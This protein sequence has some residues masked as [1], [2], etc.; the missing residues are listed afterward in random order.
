MTHPA[1]ARPIAVPAGRRQGVPLPADHAAGIS[2]PVSA[3][4]TQR[5]TIVAGAALVAAV[6]MA[7]SADTLADLGRSVGWGHRLAWSLPVSVDVLALV[8]GLAWLAAGSGRN[9]GRV[10]TL[11]TVGVSVLLNAVG[12]LVS[13][14]H[15]TT[16]P[17]LVIA[18][19]AV[20]PLAA[21]LAVHLGATVN[22]DRTVPSA[23]STP[24]LRT[25]PS[26]PYITEAEQE[27]TDQRPCGDSTCG[28]ADQTGP[29][30]REP[31]PADHPL[32]APDQRTESAA[33]H[34]DQ[35]ADQAAGSGP[36]EAALQQRTSKTAGHASAES[37]QSA[38]HQRAAQ[39]GGP[40]LTSDPAH[41]VQVAPAD[42]I[43]ARDHPMV[44]DHTGQ[45]TDNAGV[46]ISAHHAA[47]P[48]DQRTDPAPD[49]GDRSAGPQ[50]IPREVIE[51]ARR[52]A[53]AE[54]R[55]TRRAIRP[56]LR[57]HGIKVSN[58]L[59]SDLQARL[60]ADPALAHLPR[61]TKKTR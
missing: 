43:P 23:E 29:G 38:D 13:T 61:T 20:P 19:S 26:A 44:A 10:L 58:E 48:P 30:R 28:P 47:Q 24:P 12:H 27:T 50:D 37:S 39:A 16:G 49:P 40:A 56:H 42:H 53:L 21:A 17:L 2:V 45:A 32:E 31:A 54:G 60:H 3:S 14:G 22:A 6:A 34:P 15:L 5:I 35:P 55:M 4:K 51:V 25:T 33:E 41:P 11:I 36:Q 57:E 52:A 1:V 8:A 9:L 18:V 46:S 7:A 59:F